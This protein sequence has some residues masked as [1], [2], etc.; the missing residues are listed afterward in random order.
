MIL[1]IGGAFQGKLDYVQATYPGLTYCRC[2]LDKP[3][4]DMTADVIDSLHLLALAQLRAGVNTQD[5]LEERLEALAGK[6]IIADDISS[7]VVPIEAEMREWRE[8][9][10]RSLAM[11]SRH[12]DEVTRL[13][14]GIATRIK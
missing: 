7:G 4:L 14:C 10:G 5:Y 9:L 1:V 3:D 11:L 2:S 13:F 12:A 8:V 6:V